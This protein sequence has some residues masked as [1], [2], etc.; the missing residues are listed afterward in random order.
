MANGSGAPTLRC[1]RRLY[2]PY[3]EICWMA[4]PQRR[5]N[6]D[7]LKTFLQV[8]RCSG[9]LINRWARGNSLTRK[10]VEKCRGR[11]KI[12]RRMFESCQPGA[13]L[14]IWKLLKVKKNAALLLALKAR[15]RDN[16][17]PDE[18]RRSGSLISGRGV[19]SGTPPLTVEKGTKRFRH[20]HDDRSP[21]I[22]A[23]PLAEMREW[24]RMS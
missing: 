17:L 11:L 24:Q 20:R 4:K 9:C 12:A 2:Q 15:T 5:N 21:L 8:Y 22:H 14:G 7:Y 19:L 18:R 1:C 13:L 3:R 16:I 6:Q 23:D 10:L